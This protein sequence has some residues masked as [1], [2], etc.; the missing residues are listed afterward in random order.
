MRAGGGSPAAAAAGLDGAS[1]NPQLLALSA[2][3]QPAAG[4]VSSAGF[5][6]S[7]FTPAGAPVPAQAD[8]SMAHAHYISRL[9]LP[10]PTLI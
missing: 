9:E 4:A 10:A 1:S 6:A 7:N 3:L 8:P 5:F 2:V